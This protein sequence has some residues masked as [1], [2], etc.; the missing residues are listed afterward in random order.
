MDIIVRKKLK[1]VNPFELKGLPDLVVLT[2]E[3]GSG[4]TQ[5][6]EYLYTSS[7][8]ENGESLVLEHTCLSNSDFL[9][10]CTPIIQ[11]GS[12]TDQESMT[13]PSEIRDDDKR[14]IHLV[15]RPVATPVIDVGNEYDLDRIKLEGERLAQ[16]HLF[17]NNNPQ[18]KD[19]SQLSSAFIKTLGIVKSTSSI[20]RE[21]KVPE[22]TLK[23]LEMINRIEKHFQKD[24]SK[25]PFYYISLLPLPQNGVFRAN[26]RFLF[27]QYWAREQ[28]GL[29]PESK[30]WDQFNEMG[31]DL[32]FKFEI[33]EPRLSEIRFDVR[34]RDKKK[35][36]FISPNSLSSGEK[37]VFSLFLALYSTQTLSTKPE[38]ILLDEPDAY[39]HPSLSS[40]MLHVLEDFFIKKYRVKI[41]LTTHSPST[42]ALSP[43]Q[44]LFIMDP[45]SGVMKKASK[46]DA[47]LSLTSGLNT[48]SVFYENHRQ[49]FVEAKNDAFVLDHVFYLAMQR[50]WL[51]SNDIQ[52]HFIYVGDEAMEGGCSKVQDIVLKLR[53]AGNQTVFGLI[54]W[55]KKNSAKESIFV[56]GNQNRYAIDNYL[57]DPV[58]I[59]LLFLDHE[60]EKTKIGFLDVDSIVGFAEMSNEKIQSIVDQIIAQLTPNI[61]SALLSKTDLVD[62]SLANEQVYRVPRWFFEIRGHD[63]V[64]Y[65]K[66]SF[67]FLNKFKKEYDLY[68]RIVNLAY[69]NY[70]GV[71]PKDIIDTLIDLQ[72]A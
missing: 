68:K 15:Y 43:E 27:Y 54:D 25:D 22:I 56:L 7:L 41:I 72:D 11:I 21:M 34:L 66:K 58:S 40:T 63:M 16:K 64:G 71:I 29:R 51:R 26:L 1:S 3:N 30:P 6:L 5:L 61:P 62:Y 44:S 14:L 55:D 31:N 45:D 13:F 17:V 19:C 32:G 33:D 42:V 9:E 69:V 59:S 10:C 20:G 57:L 46:K 65:Y 4:K 53:G 48:L 70:P 2:G 24:Y 60:K 52:L 37:V 50:N 12:E 18:F 28:A 35:G 39:L 8:S 67:P 23:D 49:V 36:Y 38:V 47:I